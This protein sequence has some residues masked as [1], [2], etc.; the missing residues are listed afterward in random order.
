M[1]EPWARGPRRT[2]IMALCHHGRRWPG[3]QVVPPYKAVV[4]HVASHRATV[5]GMPCRF[6]EKISRGL[7]SDV[8]ALLTV[9]AIYLFPHTY[10]PAR[11]NP[12]AA[13]GQ[14]ALKRA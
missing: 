9:L 1:D 14:L 6:D 10:A 11:I 13:A 3:Q 4:T 5:N 12:H 2:R 7:E 8:T